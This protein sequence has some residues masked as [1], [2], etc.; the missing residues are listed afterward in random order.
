M[1][2]AYL[3]SLTLTLVLI[4]MLTPATSTW[5]SLRSD[6]LALPAHVFAIECQAGKILSGAVRWNG[7]AD[8]DAYLYP[9]GR[10]LMY[11]RD[12]IASYLSYSS[13]V[14]NITYNV[15]T[16]GT[17]YLRVY[18]YSIGS[19]QPYTVDLSLSPNTTATPLTFTSL[20]SQK[21][22]MVHSIPLSMPATNLSS[23]P[24]RYRITNISNPSVGLSM[25]LVSTESSTVYSWPAGEGFC[26]PSG[27]G[28]GGGLSAL[29]VHTVNN[30]TT[31]SQFSYVIETGT[32][33]S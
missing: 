13:N 33:L 19:T 14:E 11:Y 29:F 2:R 3:L 18:A 23:I 7:T 4:L 24:I 12:S 28:N 15:P 16:S 1:S 22:R 26:L 6:T 20:F 31:L 25:S 30:M 9:S 17:Y 27:F 21:N 10:R 5:S 32:D 8:L